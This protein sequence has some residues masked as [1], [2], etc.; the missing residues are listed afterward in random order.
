[1][2][3]LGTFSQYTVVSEA[4]VRQDRRRHPAGRGRAWSAAACPPAGARRSTPPTCGPGET[5]VVVGVGG[6]GIERRPGRPAGRRAERHRRR[7]GRVQAGEGRGVRRHAHAPSAEEAHRRRSASSTW[8]QRRR[9]GDHAPSASST[10]RSSAR[11]SSSTGKGGRVV[12]T[13]I[14]NP[15]QKARRTSRPCSLTLY[16]KQLAARSSARPTRCR[17][18]QAARPLPGGPAQARRAGHPAR[19]RSTT[20]TRATQDMRDGKNIRGVIIHEH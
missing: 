19:T 20:S 3:M 5:V 1:M 14:G 12:V 15:T 11:R 10:T 4:S 16:E 9:Q 13:G 7:P 8:G 2:C 18:P 17:H 6:V